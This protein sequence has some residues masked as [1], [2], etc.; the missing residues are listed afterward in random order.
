MFDVLW[1]LQYEILG[2]LVEKQQI[3]LHSHHSHHL[4]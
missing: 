2:A 4:E 3:Y 1:Q